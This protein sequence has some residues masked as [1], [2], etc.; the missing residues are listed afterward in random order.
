MAFA[1][2]DPE[3]LSGAA[4]GLAALAEDL[5]HDASAVAGL[6]R[7]RSAAAGDP[8]VARLLE[9]ALA[10]TGGVLVAAGSIAH[11]LATGA[12][13]AGEQLTVATGGR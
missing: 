10:V 7:R 6:G 2:G 3:T 4:H 1:G 5:A 13:T 8:E 12:T 11:G 9:A